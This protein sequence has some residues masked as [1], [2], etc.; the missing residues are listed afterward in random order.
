M[1]GQIRPIE[2]LVKVVNKILEKP[3]DK[4]QKNDQRPSDKRIEAWRIDSYSITP[5]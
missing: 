1:P 3:K 2:K 4:Q 5:R